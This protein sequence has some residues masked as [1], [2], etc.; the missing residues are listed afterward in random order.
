MFLL[1]CCITC[2]SDNLYRERV[3]NFID[4]TV[5]FMDEKQIDKNYK[6]GY[7]D[8]SDMTDV[9]SVIDNNNLVKSLN[10]NGYDI[11]YYKLPDDFKNFRYLPLNRIENPSDNMCLVIVSDNG[12]MIWNRFL[13]NESE[14]PILDIVKVDDDN[15]IL[16]GHFLGCAMVDYINV[17]E[18]LRIDE[19][20]VFAIYYDIIQ[21]GI[22]DPNDKLI[23]ANIISD[24]IVSLKY[25]GMKEYWRIKNSEEDFNKYPKLIPSDRLLWT[26]N[27]KH[28]DFGYK[29]VYYFNYDNEPTVSQLKEKFPEDTFYNDISITKNIKEEMNSAQRSE[30]E[31]ENFFVKIHKNIMTYI[32][33]IINKWQV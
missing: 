12:K 14:S 7:Y 10:L 32:A 15:Y 9:K 33:N 19:Y 25:Q 31:K 29:S 3:Y 30:L 27:T 5:C 1:V 22:P 17:G 16:C 23:G 20:R 26:N 28:K 24:N 6:D 2:F 11:K 21:S 13:I 18:K 4:K 8:W